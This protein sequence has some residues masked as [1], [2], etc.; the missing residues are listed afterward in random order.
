ML[1]LPKDTHAWNPF[2]IF[3][4][5][6]VQADETVE[7]QEN[8]QTVTLLE[9]KPIIDPQAKTLDAV[10]I[11]DGSALVAESGPLGTAAD[12]ADTSTND[13][14]SVYTVRKGDTVAAIAEMFS[15][16][17]NTILWAN[18]LTRGQAL[19][20]GR[21]LVILPVTGV[22]YTIKKGDTL[23]SLA[24][25]YSA[26]A[27]DIAVF[28]GIAPNAVL[29]VGDTIIIP[30]G[31]IAAAPPASKSKGSVSRR[32]IPGSGGP[33]QNGYYIK[34]VA[35][36]RTQG[37][38]GHNGTDWGCSVGTTIRAAAGGTVVV[39]S[40]SGGYNGGY[41]NYIV[42]AHPNGTQTLY[43]HLSKVSIESG[44]TVRQGQNIGTTGGRPGTFG[45][46]R[47]TGAHLHFEVRGAKNPGVDG[48]WAVQ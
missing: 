11:V 38:H 40:G 21:T 46:G 42:I 45:A 29:I 19:V 37:L 47:S 34:P 5:G 36:P 17:T 22:Q 7:N 13:Q 14:I 16:S 30:D 25:K 10:E 35:C 43:A 33:A 31:V 1:T 20:E 15:V 9:A 24:K 2:G 44:D 4:A 8:S 41:G 6:T 28:N 18:D 27:G 26:D 12:V 48:S 32:V 39:A 3:S 23:A